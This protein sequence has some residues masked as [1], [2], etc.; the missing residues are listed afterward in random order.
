[1]N[2]LFELYLKNNIDDLRILTQEINTFEHD[3]IEQLNDDEEFA[4]L[5]MSS[6]AKAS[7]D[8]WF[9]RGN[10][11]SDIVDI[12]II[13]YS[14]PAKVGK[15]DLGGAVGGALRAWWTG[16]GMFVSAVG[17]GLIASAA[18]CFH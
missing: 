13:A 16:G 10:E 1:M 7:I 12:D 2:T 5:A 8:Y 3:A 17:F 15:A 18:A 11:W 14:S 9:L 6:V 4:V